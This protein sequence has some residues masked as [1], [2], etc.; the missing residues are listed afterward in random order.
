MSSSFF[1]KG[2]SRQVLKRK[3][4]KVKKPKVTK[5]S[6][7]NLENGQESSDSDLDLKKFSDAEESESDHETAD[8]KKLRLAKK[9]LEEIEKEEAKRNE[10]KQIDD[11]AIG[12]RLQK[13]YLEQKGKLRVEVADSYVAPSEGDVKLVRVR[14][15]QL[16]LT[17]VCISSNGQFAF[18]GSKCSS[19]VKWDIKEKKKLA[20]MTHKTH[21]DYF[22]GSITAIAISTDTK[23]LATSDQSSNIQIWD[24]HTMKH[25]HT[26]KGHKD[27]VTGLVFRKNTHDMYSSSKDRSVK[28]WSL[29]EMAYVE[30][31][32]GHQSPITSIDALT[33]ERVISAGGRDATVRIWKI[34]EESHLIFNGPE[35]SLDEVR[36][37]DEEHFVSGSDNGS[38]CVWSL[39]KKKPLCVVTQ[40]HGVENEVPRWITSLATVLNSDVFASG[41]YD[42]N[43]RLWKVC[44][45]YRKV[46]PLFSI[47]ANGFVNSMQFT[48][49]GQ[50]LYAGLGQE[51]KN[52]R[53]WRY[54]SYKNGVLVV[55]F[56]IN[57]KS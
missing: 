38:L 21:G 55:N 7:P 22:K 6:G 37:L 12:K 42:D 33:R 51:H 31:L 41:S 8:Q 53:W 25:L 52:G 20:T 26:F 48:S 40:A 23:F 43:I 34:V 47:A 16:P 1:L 54:A 11:D 19:I 32:F 4:E 28:I 14:E 44:E 24:P 10:L 17:C 45:S 49:D 30:T 15:H 29:D 36:L 18:T 9:Y 3:G 57:D 5:Q 56:K 39:M 50:T 35:G 27:S 2:K 13:D 46:L